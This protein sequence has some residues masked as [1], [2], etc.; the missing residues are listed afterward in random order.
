MSHNY[1][2]PL[3]SGQKI[4]RLLTR[5]PPSWHVRMERETGSAT[6]RAVVHAPETSEGAWSDA[7]MDPA[8][9]LEDAWRRNRT[10]LA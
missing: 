9:A 5:I 6:W 8:D 1:A 4:E 2:K 3:T 7:H 10:L